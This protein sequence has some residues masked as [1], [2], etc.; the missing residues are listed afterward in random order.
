MVFLNRALEKRSGK[1]N[2]NRAQL[3]RVGKL[4]N[5][6]VTNVKAAR[7]C[8]ILRL[9]NESRTISQRQTKSRS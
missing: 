9:S 5:V 6:K 8:D 1:C 3:S 4:G 7:D 2:R